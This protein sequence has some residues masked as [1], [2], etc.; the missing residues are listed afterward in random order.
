MRENYDE[1]AG[2]L[3]ALADTGTFEQASSAIRELSKSVDKLTTDVSTL[4]EK[5][6]ALVEQLRLL[7]GFT[8]GEAARRS[9]PARDAL[10]ELC[11]LR[12]DT[13]TLGRLEKIWAVEP[14]SGL[15]HEFAIAMGRV[16]K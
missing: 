3:D 16:K 9:T 2:K 14:S 7:E 11:V 8:S 13:K 15:S 10:K 5:N 6:A 1:I 12:G 4:T